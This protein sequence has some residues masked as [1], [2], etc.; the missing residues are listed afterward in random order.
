LPNLQNILINFAIIVI[1][2]LLGCT[3]FVDIQQNGDHQFGRNRLA[4][5]PRLNFTCNGRIINIR[6]KV[7]SNSN[8]N[9]F[10]S[11]QVWRVSSFGLVTYNRI[12]ETQL[13]SDDQMISGSNS[14]LETNTTLTG[15]DRIEFQSG[16]VIGYYHP[17]DSR[18]QVRDIKT[19]GYFLYRFDELPPPNPVNLNEA[20]NM[21][22]FRQP[23]IQFMIGMYIYVHVITSYILT[24]TLKN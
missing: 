11:L 22:N 3:D 13:Q 12:G 9:A 21:F 7:T 23:L 6:A 15:D 5:I 2:F 1:C 17:P 10:P 19:D 20:N 16:D 4:I 8:R 24:N 14:F 18:Y